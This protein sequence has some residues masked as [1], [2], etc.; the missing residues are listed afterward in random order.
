MTKIKRGNFTV[1]KEKQLEELQKRIPPILNVNIA[2][3]KK[4]LT[5]KKNIY[6]F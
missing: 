5:D 1:S 2:I 4:D 6:K 3:F